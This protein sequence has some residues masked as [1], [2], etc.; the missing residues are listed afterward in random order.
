MKIT[1]EYE[2]IEE[3]E[4]YTKIGGQNRDGGLL[5]VLLDIKEKLY[6]SGQ[7]DVGGKLHK[8]IKDIDDIANDGDYNV[9][10]YFEAVSLFN[11]LVERNPE[12]EDALRQGL[13]NRVGD[14]EIRQGLSD[15]AYKKLIN[16]LSGV[17]DN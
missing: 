13:F 15:D 6:Q 5:P 16:Y 3:F 11:E 12:T 17:R 10:L 7:D 8:D 2:S 14:Y 9:D 1:V 4:R